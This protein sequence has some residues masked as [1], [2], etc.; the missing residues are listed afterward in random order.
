VLRK[1]VVPIL[2]QIGLHCHDMTQL[3]AV[4]QFNHANKHDYRL[5][6]LKMNI[7]STAHISLYTLYQTWLKKQSQNLHFASPFVRRNRVD[8]CH[9]TINRTRSGHGVTHEHGWQALPIQVRGLMCDW[10]RIIA[11]ENRLVCFMLRRHRQCGFR[12]ASSRCWL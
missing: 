7:Q 3:F 2:V 12:I 9:I 11:F 6:E 10:R 4:F 1:L 5:V 8:D